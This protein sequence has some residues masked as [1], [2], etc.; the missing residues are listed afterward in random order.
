MYPDKLSRKYKQQR[1]K[2]AEKDRVC[3]RAAQRGTRGAAAA[4]LT[5]AQRL[6]HGACRRQ[7]HAGGRKCQRKAP[8]AYAQRV[9]PHHLR[10]HTVGY[11]HAEADAHGAHYYRCE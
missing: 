3:K 2:A 5:V 9:K 8:H 7:I 1:R 11:P 4:L 10:S 6:C